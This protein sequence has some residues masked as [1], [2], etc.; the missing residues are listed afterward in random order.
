MENSL[1]WFGYTVT[2]KCMVVTWRT[3]L[4]GSTMPTQGPTPDAQL[5][6]MGLN[7]FASSVR[8]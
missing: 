1:K 4:N 6:A 3:R 8:P 2:L 7:G 5:A